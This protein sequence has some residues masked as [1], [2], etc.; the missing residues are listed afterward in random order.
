MIRIFPNLQHLDRIAILFGVLISVASLCW[1]AVYNATLAILLIATFLLTCYAWYVTE[2]YKR[3]FP[4]NGLLIF[5]AMLLFVIIQWSLLA[6]SSQELLTADFTM[7]S[8]PLYGFSQGLWLEDIGHFLWPGLCFMLAALITTRKESSRYLLLSILYS[9][10][11][12]VATTFLIEKH[13]LNWAHNTFSHGFVNPN[14]AASYLGILLIVALV[15][16][17]RFLRKLKNTRRAAMKDIFYHTS[18]KQIGILLALCFATFLFLVGLFAT[19]SRG[20]IILAL[21]SILCCAGLIL[22]KSS[23][24][25]SRNFN[26]TLIILFFFVTICMIGY[27]SFLNYGQEFSGS[28]GRDGLSAHYRP[29]LYASTVKM[30]ADHPLLGTGLGNFPSAFPPYRSLVTDPEGFH[31][32]AHNTYLEI[33]AEMGIPGLL[34]LLAMM[35]IILRQLLNNYLNSDTVHLPSV[36]GLT[37]F[38]FVALHSLI[39]FP[40]QIPSIAGTTLV[41]LTLCVMSPRKVRRKSVRRRVRRRRSHSSAMPIDLG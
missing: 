29:P 3:R 28:F 13:S 19:A 12:L 8:A 4:L 9:S 39:D 21:F 41:I 15:E 18:L 14:N 2:P 34:A 37:L 24:S 23:R 33:F 22:F 40:L 25:R 26:S 7:H 27:W 31:E 35:V 6:P 38:V 1:G 16:S 11:L 32:K 10:T 30:A 20:G 36:A 17:F 5:S